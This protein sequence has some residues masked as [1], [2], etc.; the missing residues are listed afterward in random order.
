[1]CKILWFQGVGWSEHDQDIP[2][3]EYRKWHL[4]EQLTCVDVAL[5]GRFLYKCTAFAML[6]DNVVASIFVC[7]YIYTGN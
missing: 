3:L 1:M 2:H 6:H 4:K 7:M 5:I